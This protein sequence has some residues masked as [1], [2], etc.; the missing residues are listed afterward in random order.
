LVLQPTMLDLGFHASR[1]AVI[2]GV[3]E[4]APLIKKM[5]PKTPCRIKHLDFILQ[6]RPKP[7][8]NSLDHLVSAREQRL[9]HHQA[10]RLGGL[11]IDD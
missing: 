4:L 8:G 10:K 3:H 6:G 9:R 5:H 1:Q 2:I 11:E 7:A